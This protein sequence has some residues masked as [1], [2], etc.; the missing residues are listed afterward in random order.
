MPKKP[1]RS[2]RPK[3]PGLP[4]PLPSKEPEFS[5][6]TNLDEMDGIVDRTMLP[7][8]ASSPGSGFESSYYS[9]SFSTSDGG[10]NFM[11]TSSSPPRL[12]RT[13]SPTTVFSNP[14]SPS[15]RRKGV[16][17]N[18]D[19]RKVSPKT[20]VPPAAVP[21]PPQ[22]TAANAE[23]HSPGWI[24]PESWAVEKEG[25]VPDVPDYTSSDEE[26][27]MPLKP[28]QQ[29]HQRRRTRHPRR[30]Q[31]LTTYQMRIHRL[32]GTYHVVKCPL[33]KSVAELI[34][35][36]NRRL[37]LDPTRETHSLYVKERERGELSRK[38]MLY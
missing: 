17:P 7:L 5:L 15:S 21:V 37:L 2:K 4:P 20:V 3:S 32:D 1:R 14:F 18:L 6:D 26:G 28:Q 24:A 13:T 8:D 30:P 23:P 19:L 10:L 34:P 38:N 12:H 25:E 35:A 27:S 36:L 11:T 9:S 16:P 22:P 29:Q 31:S 33:N